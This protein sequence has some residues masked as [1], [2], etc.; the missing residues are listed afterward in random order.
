M[1]VTVVSGAVCI[2]SYKIILNLNPTQTSKPNPKP[3]P[4]LDAI[5]GPTAILVIHS[6]TLYI[7]VRPDTLKLLVYIYT[8]TIII[9][10]NTFLKPNQWSVEI[11]N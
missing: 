11:I 8:S 3:N 1:R 4:S 6:R 5:V 10:K 7:L 2:A 9:L